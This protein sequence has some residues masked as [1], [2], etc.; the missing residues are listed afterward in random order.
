MSQFRRL[1]YFP[2]VLVQRCISF[3]I[4]S[5]EILYKTNLAIVLYKSVHPHRIL[6]FILWHK[7]ASADHPT[8]ISM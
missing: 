2:I 3:L 4:M 8:R 6:S 1:L 7:D 5:S